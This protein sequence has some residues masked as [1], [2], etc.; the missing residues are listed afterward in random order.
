MSGRNERKIAVR[1]RFTLLAQGVVVANVD[2][3][4]GVQRVDAIFDSPCKCSNRIL[5]D[6]FRD[7]TVPCISL[8]EKFAE[9]EHWITQREKSALR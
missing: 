9:L 5:M 8:P 7:D 1:R 4:N 3:I 6:A 2:T